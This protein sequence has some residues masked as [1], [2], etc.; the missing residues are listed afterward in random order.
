MDS[1]RCGIYLNACRKVCELVTDR[2]VLAG[3]IGPYSLIGRLMGIEDAM[4]NCFDDPDMVH[5]TLKKGNEFIIA[6]IKAYKEA[7]ANGVLLAEPL[8]G[9]LS[10]AMADEFSHDYVKE[11]IDAV[12]DDEFAVIYHNC[13]NN[14]PLMKK[15]IY[16]LGAMGYHFGDV[17]DMETMLKDSPEDALILGNISPSAQFLSG[18]PASMKQ[19]VES[20]MT[21]FGGYKNFVLSSGCDIPYQ[22][23][24]RNI[25]AFFEAHKSFRDQ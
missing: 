17:I 3:V 2:P 5:E 15:D 9:M 6:L 12:Q 21:R 25:D 20:L 11:I 8:T 1:G 16:N 19:A 14:V 10:P 23:P 7:G 22:S 24:W 13:G 4:M 18:T